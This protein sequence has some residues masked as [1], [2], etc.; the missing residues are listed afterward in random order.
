MSRY[1]K[2]TIY[3]SIIYPHF[4]YCSTLLNFC[5]KKQSHKLQV[6]Q[7]RGMKLIL[8]CSRY[9][10]IES[11]LRSLGWMNVSQLYFYNTMQ[12]VYKI[13]K[14]LLPNYLTE[15]LNYPQHAHVTRHRNSLRVV[16]RKKKLCFDALFSGGISEYNRLPRVIKDS[17]SL[18]SFKTKLKC[19]ILN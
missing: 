5:N 6:L 17:T 3:K 15:K 2:L 1:A 11:M 18:C 12:F 9:T 14:G 19:H 7:N 16:R 8:G 10:S 13:K 4:I